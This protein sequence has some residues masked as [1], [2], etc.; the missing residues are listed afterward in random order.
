MPIVV[1]Q[2][3]RITRPFA[4]HPLNLASQCGVGRGKHAHLA[5]GLREGSFWTD[6]LGQTLVATSCWQ[7]TVAQSHVW[8]PCCG[9]VLCASHLYIFAFAGQITKLALP[10]ALIRPTLQFCPRHVGLGFSYFNYNRNCNLAITSSL[11][12]SKLNETT[13]TASFRIESAACMFEQ[14]TAT[15][16]VN[17]LGFASR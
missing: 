9:V 4:S 1:T 13:H 17:Y 8:Y 11:N 12:L 15:R 3:A 10:R 7:Y 16:E 2:S 5:T 14:G 6:V